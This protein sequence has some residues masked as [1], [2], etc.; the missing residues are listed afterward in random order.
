MVKYLIINRGLL[1]RM[2]KELK[3]KLSIKKTIFLKWV[4]LLSKEFLKDELQIPENY[5]LFNVHYPQLPGKYK[6]ELLRFHATSKINNMRQKKKKNPTTNAC[7]GIEQEQVFT[8]VGGPLKQS[9]A[10]TKAWDSPQAWKA[11]LHHRGSQFP[12]PNRRHP[13][14]SPG[15]WNS[16]CLFP[17]VNPLCSCSTDPLLHRGSLL[18]C[19]VATA[20]LVITA[21]L[22]AA[23]TSEGWRDLS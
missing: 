19:S 13:I 5:I 21:A 20:A 7:M 18:H 11:P 3:K 16:P 8:E 14:T 9:H 1:A 2:Y 12:H 22:A 4:K 6:S 23:V 17:Y 15:A 10:I